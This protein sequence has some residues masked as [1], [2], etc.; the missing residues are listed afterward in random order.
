MLAYIVSFRLDEICSFA[1][2]V[3]TW[4]LAVKPTGE[5]RRQ[6]GTNEG[7]EKS[8]AVT[9]KPAALHGLRARMGKF[10][11]SDLVGGEHAVSGACRRTKFYKS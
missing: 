11:G 2:R 10:S 7:V 4:S 9:F 1:L 6:N 5:P 8:R 3:S